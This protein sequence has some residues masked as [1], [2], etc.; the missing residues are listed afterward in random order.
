MLQTEKHPDMKAEASTCLSA[1]KEA[2]QQ[3]VKW[4]GRAVGDVR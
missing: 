4:V 1:G 3:D 2:A